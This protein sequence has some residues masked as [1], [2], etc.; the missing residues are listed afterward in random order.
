MTTTM[1]RRPVVVEEVLCEIACFLQTILLFSSWL[2]AKNSTLL[3]FIPL[4]SALS[5][6]HALKN[7]FFFFLVND[8]SFLTIFA[9]TKK[10]VQLYLFTLPL[11]YEFRLFNSLLE[12]ECHHRI[13]SQS[14]KCEV[15]VL[16]IS[17]FTEKMLRTRLSAAEVT[18][19]D[20]YFSF[21]AQEPYKNFDCC[22]YI[23]LTPPKK[24]KKC[25]KSD[26]TFVMLYK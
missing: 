8:I 18:L 12:I 5:L 14:V 22:A 6:T 13:V 26:K 3:G 19:V 17:D 11:F 9:K 25:W 7:L 23:F 16:D 4:S 24:V 10:R 2:R 21:F 15:S 20:K 1:L